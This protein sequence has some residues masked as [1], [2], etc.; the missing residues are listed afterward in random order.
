[1]IGQVSLQTRQ[2]QLDDLLARVC[3]ELQLSP[4]RYQEAVDR[5]QAVC[6][7]L[8]AEGSPVS[9]YMPTIY[10]Q[11]SMRIGTTVKPL[12]REE[13]DLDFVCEFQIDPSTIETPL[14]LLRH[15]AAR[16]K[17]HK[18]YRDL[19]EVK[20]RCVRLNYANEFHMDILPACPDPASGEDCIVVPD[21]QS[22]WWKPS[23]PRGYAEWF[24][25]RCIVTVPYQFSER[26]LAMDSAE[27]IPAQEASHEKATLKHVVQLLKRWRDIYYQDRCDVAPIS[28][29]LTTLAAQFYGGHWS[30]SES[31]TTILEGIEG[32]VNAAMPGRIY[33]LNPANTDEDLSERWDDPTQYAA[34]IEGIRAL[35]AAW[36]RL[37]LD[38]TLEK[39]VG[40]LEGLA[41][42]P[43]KEAFR[44]QARDLQA[45]RGA[46]VLK[47][48]STGA[49]SVM[50]GASVRPNTFHGE[51]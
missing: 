3:F 9:N 39:S 10:P 4:T 27:P 19:L 28:M 25:E 5:Y 22:A 15:V 26:K 6:R 13:H 1:M 2:A 11:G 44:K 23:N 31:M 38:Q 7:W 37:T 20:N 49:L 42:E 45:A 41:G 34:F 46:D 51:E 30:V 17:E 12:G 48:G 47:T 32:A 40:I 35:R 18:V 24:E 33:V 21:R 8:E 43:T 29:V 50:S 16:L 36:N 14:E